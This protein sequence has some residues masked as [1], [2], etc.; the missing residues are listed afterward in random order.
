MPLVTPEGIATIQLDYI[1][2]GGG[3]SG[4]SLAARYAPLRVLQIAV[5]TGGGVD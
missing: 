1:I 2:V 4:L 3:T 5:L